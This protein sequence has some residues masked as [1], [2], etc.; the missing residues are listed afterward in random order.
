MENDL[1]KRFSEIRGQRMEKLKTAM[2]RDSS[3]LHIPLDEIEAYSDNPRM[4]TNPKFDEIK[5]SI[6]SIGVQHRIIVTKRPGHDKY[7]I[8]QGGNTRLKCLQ[9]LFEETGDTR[10]SRAPCIYKAWTDE[11]DL[12]V[13]HM[14]ENSLRG[15]LNWHE[16]AHMTAMLKIKLEKKLKR[17]LSNRQ[18]Q[19]IAAQH[20]ISVYREQMNL[21]QYTVQRLAEPFATELALGMGRTKVAQLYRAEHA[22]RKL[23]KEAGLAETKFEKFIQIQFKAMKGLTDL[24]QLAENVGQFFH[25]RNQDFHIDEFS[26]VLLDYST[27]SGRA[28]PSLEDFLYPPTAGELPTAPPAAQESKKP[29][30]QESFDAEDGFEEIDLDDEFDDIDDSREFDDAG[31]KEESAPPPRSLYPGALRRR[32]VDARSQIH[33]SAELI[34]TWA[35]CGECVTPVPYG[36]GFLVMHLPK[37]FEQWQLDQHPEHKQQRDQ[38]WWLLLELSQTQAAIRAQPKDTLLLARA[39]NS[40]LLAFYEAH[41]RLQEVLKLTKAAGVET[42][43]PLCTVRSMLLTTEQI[44]YRSWNQFLNRYRRL[45]HLADRENYNLWKQED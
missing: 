26:R 16:R 33:R 32:V 38:A 12:L 34:A 24:Y 30:Q 4:Y 25:K 8:C 15:N 40:D 36:F 22:V 7:V 44:L 41:G 29:D 39:E 13:G 3:A 20:G 37:Q 14:V 43:T 6:R 28:I 45:Q 1:Q 31:E 35:D 2:L 5:E 18:F 42:P 10:F 23:W 11:V 27:S 9:E 17:E 19:K 21:Q